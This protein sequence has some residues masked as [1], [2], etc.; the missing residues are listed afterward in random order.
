MKSNDNFTFSQEDIDSR[1]QFLISQIGTSFDKRRFD[2]DKEENTKICS[3]LKKA[4]TLLNWDI[5]DKEREYL[6]ISISYLLDNDT[7]GHDY[8]AN[9]SAARGHIHRLEIKY[10]I[11][12]KKRPATRV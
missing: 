2:I 9:I 12:G 3:L 1:I 6:C 11:S 8:A 7:Q 4:K 10:N 5:T